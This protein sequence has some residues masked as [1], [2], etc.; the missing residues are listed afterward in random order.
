MFESTVENEPLRLNRPVN[1][2]QIVNVNYSSKVHGITINGQ[3]FGSKTGSN[4]NIELGENEEIFRV[5][6]YGGES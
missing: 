3:E 4:A 5:I 1:E 2:R 6:Y